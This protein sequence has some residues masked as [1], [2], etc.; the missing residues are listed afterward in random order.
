MQ[1]SKYVQSSTNEIYVKVD[2]CLKQY[3]YVLYSGTPCQ[4]AGLYSF[5]NKIPDNL[6]TIDIICHGVP[7]PQLFKNYVRWLEQ[8]SGKKLLNYLFRNK[9]IFD[10]TGFSLKAVFS[11]KIISQNAWQ[12]PYYSSFLKGNNFRECCYHCS[13]SNLN[14]VADITIGD[15]DGIDKICPDFYAW[16]AI[17]ACLLNS[18][19]GI[20][21]WKKAKD[22][23][24]YKS[25]D[26]G[27]RK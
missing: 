25:I 1:G 27:R 14:R 20:Y 6:Y 23:F 5:L 15:L 4:V 16:K 11:N 12:D 21:L 10:R 8:R 19:K 13:Y 26:A 24:F 22:Q 7:S 2:S 18:Q 17:S 9:T 3:K